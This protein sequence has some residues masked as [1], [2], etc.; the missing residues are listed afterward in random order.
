MLDLIRK[1]QKSSL[2]KL[3]FLVIILSFVVGYAM[4][5]S[6]G[7]RQGGGTGPGDVA[8][9]INGTAISFQEYQ[10]A[11]RNLYQLYQ[12]IYREKFTPELENQL[13]LRRQALEQLVDQALLLQEADRRDIE[14]GKDELVKS[15]AEIPAFQENG[16]FSKQRYLQVLNYQRLTP[17]DFEAMQRRQ[18]LVDKVRAQLQEGITVGDAEIEQAYRR[19]NEKIDL[20]FVRLTPAL[21][22]PRVEVDQDELAAYFTDHREDFRIP[23]RVALSYVVFKP[24]DYADEVLFEEGE[25]EKYYRRHLDQF[26]IPEQVKVSHILIKVAKDA[27][28]ATRT[29]KRELAEKILDEAKSGKDFGDLARR[30]SDDPGS[31]AKGGE[32]GYFTRGTMVKPFERAAFALQPGELSG[33][34]ET[35]FG[36]HILKGEGY[37]E[38]GI[39]P[40]AEVAD[41][42]KEGLRQEKAEH[43]AMEKAMDA[44]NINRKDGSLQAAAKA[45][46][47]GVKQTDFFSENEPIEGLGDLPEVAATAFTL[48]TGKLARPVTIPEGVILFTVREK[49]ESRLPELKE[50]REK[51]IAAFRRERAGDLARKAADDLLAGLKEGKSLKTLTRKANLDVETTGLFARS[52][53]DFVPKLGNAGDL[54]EDAFK[55]TADNPAAPRVYDLEGRYVVAALKDRQQADMKAL[56]ATKRSE[57]RESLLSKKKQEAVE[58][59]LDELRKQAEISY[60]Q[61]LQSVLE[62][63]S[64][65]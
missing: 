48:P 34:V 53:G 14:V 24:A 51:V 31:A 1:K 18:L 17:D 2:I 22:E 59:K 43:L 36:F 62:G 32:L 26:E 41:E 7:D 49:R 29:K 21:F 50:V 10:S 42:V 13:N 3:A 37:I 38:A 4:L 60:T 15:I 25:L 20:A 35:P 6:P 9:N 45:S 65:L 16:S 39:K 46:D 27:D 55:L 54:A 11:Y 56:D 61:A 8:A 19:Q 30:Y 44:Y 64:R 57:L 58:S 63:N 47:L 23:A 52:Y 5:T 12:N 40:L 33:I 28:Q